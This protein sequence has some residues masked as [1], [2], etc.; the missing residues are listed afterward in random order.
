[1]VSSRRRLDTLRC[2]RRADPTVR[3]MRGCQGRSLAVSRSFVLSCAAVAARA[4]KCPGN[5]SRET[6]DRAN[7][8]SDFGPPGV[9]RLAFVVNG[10]TEA[11]SPCEMLRLF[12]YET[13][14]ERSNQK[15]LMW[16]Q[17]E[18]LF[19]LVWCVFLSIQTKRH[20]SDSTD[21]P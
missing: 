13:E 14:I 9:S 19:G 5:S 17:S 18:I 6:V 7:V 11:H 21:Y 15:N 16:I 3:S 4:P 2:Y 10:K 8:A 1:M 20:P 12:G